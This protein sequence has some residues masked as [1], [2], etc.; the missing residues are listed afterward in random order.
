MNEGAAAAYSAVRAISTREVRVSRPLTIYPA[1]TSPA[2]AR[3]SAKVDG[4]RA[5]AR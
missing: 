5:A 1:L 3:H 2:L 4:K